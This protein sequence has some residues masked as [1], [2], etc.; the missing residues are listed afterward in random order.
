MHRESPYRS[1]AVRSFGT[2]LVLLIGFGHGA[3]AQAA[4][5]TRAA[6]AGERVF[7]T[8]GHQWS[9]GMPRV[10]PFAGNGIVSRLRTEGPTVVRQ[11]D[12]RSPKARAIDKKRREVLAE[13]RDGLVNHGLKRGRQPVLLHET[14]AALFRLLDDALGPIVPKTIASPALLEALRQVP[15][16]T[17]FAKEARAA[18][19]A[20]LDLQAQDPRLIQFRDPGDIALLEHWVSTL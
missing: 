12:N 8:E 17:V 13:A 9:G 20:L 14:D 19:K 2:G 5:L 16:Q 15:D 4:N 1:L 10:R 18:V 6:R 11:R 3:V 7:M